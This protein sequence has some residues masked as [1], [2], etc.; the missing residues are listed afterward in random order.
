MQEL[1][2]HLRELVQSILNDPTYTEE[3]AEA[4]PILQRALTA[5]MEHGDLIQKVLI[6]LIGF[7]CLRLVVNIIKKLASRHRKKSIT[8]QYDSLGRKI[9]YRRYSNANFLGPS[10]W[11]VVFSIILYLTEELFLW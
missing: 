4:G 7:S 11:I 2:G 10:F 5:V 9:S 1:I 3:N 8:E 6:V